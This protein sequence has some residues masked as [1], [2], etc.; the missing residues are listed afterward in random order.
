[1]KTIERFLNPTIFAICQYTSFP[2]NISNINNVTHCYISVKVKEDFTYW[3]D[4]FFSETLKTEI[5]IKPFFIKPLAIF[6]PTTKCGLLIFTELHSADFPLMAQHIISGGILY[7][8]NLSARIKMLYR[9]YVKKILHKVL[10]YN[11]SWYNLL[12]PLSLANGTGTKWQKNI[13]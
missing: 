1:M 10:A 7:K 9:K 12:H 2:K 13:F 6:S 3:H 11:K 5:I 8:T 4:F